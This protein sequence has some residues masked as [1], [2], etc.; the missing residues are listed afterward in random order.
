MLSEFCTRFGALP[1][2]PSTEQ[3]LEVEVHDD[4]L[5]LVFR[6][7]SNMAYSSGAPCPD[8]VVKNVYQIVDGRLKLMTQT[9]GTHIPAYAMPEKI[10]V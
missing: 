1:P 4:G 7:P 8:V 10:I 6:R 9:H 3:V 2:R 5:V